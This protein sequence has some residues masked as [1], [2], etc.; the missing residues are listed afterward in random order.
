MPSCRCAT[1]LTT[2]P[3][4]K[5][6][7]RSL[8]SA[9]CLSLKRQGLPQA[10]APDD[11]ELETNLETAEK[12]IFT[13]ILTD[14]G[15]RPEE[16]KVGRW[17]TPSTASST[18]NLPVV[19][20]VTVIQALNESIQRMSLSP[21]AS[22]TASPTASTTSQSSYIRNAMSILDN[23]HASIT[24][25][26]D[27]LKDHPSAHRLGQMS[28]VVHRSRQ[29]IEQVERGRAS[30]DDGVA[31]RKQEVAMIVDSVDGRITELQLLQPHGP[32]EY[33]SGLSFAINYESIQTDCLFKRSSF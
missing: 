20:T 2:H 8:Y 15:L 3:T 23:V 24:P 26:S 21:T 18:S 4:G 14:P 6:W 32:K 33:Q 17:S 12:Q 31:R 9:H 11:D 19:D 25:F 1:C 28:T 29:A 7:P 13:S 30:K 16:P 5:D 22:T 10:T 27:E